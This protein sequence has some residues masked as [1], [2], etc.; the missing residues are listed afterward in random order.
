ML[1]TYLLVLLTPLKPVKEICKDAERIQGEWALV[2]VFS[3]GEKEPTPDDPI[4]MCIGPDRIRTIGKEDAWSYQL[5]REGQ[6]RT[7]DLIP[8]NGPLK[9][10]TLRGI[11]Q[12]DGNVLQI[13]LVPDPDASRPTDMSAQGKHRVLM[14]TRV[15][16]LWWMPS[17]ELPVP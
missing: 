16:R 10:K 3:R 8:A 5:G 12:L 9:G 4:P 13:C 17:L 6:L 2:A 1:L 11:Y 14:L 15:V 7:I